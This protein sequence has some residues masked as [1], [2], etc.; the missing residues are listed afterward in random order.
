M[1]T[2]K[3]RQY[4]YSKEQASWALWSLIRTY[5]QG[6][7]K[8][9]VQWVIGLW[10][11]QPFTTRELAVDTGERA[12]HSHQCHTTALRSHVLPPHPGMQAWQL[13]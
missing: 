5:K 1:S 7:E 13:N 10:T 4:K 8:H 3:Q 2:H 12:H 11:Q 6:T 9:S